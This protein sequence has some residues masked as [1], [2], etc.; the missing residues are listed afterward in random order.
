[1]SNK[2][3]EQLQSKGGKDCYFTPSAVVEHIIPYIPQNAI[4]WC[5]FDTVDSEFVKIIS[6]T[7]RVIYSHI[8]TGHDY[9]EF[10]PEKW[11]VMISNPPFTAKAKIFER[12]ISFGKPFALVMTCQWLND[13]APARLRGTTDRSL[14]L[15]FFNKRVHFIDGET[16]EVNKKT[17][18]GSAYYCS[19]FLPRQIMWKTL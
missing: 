6:R 10:E 7:H 15:M 8:D 18:F 4:V 3:S 11:D 1:M 19:D 17:T 9:Y 16:G 2:L 5:P 12:A 14:E 13:S